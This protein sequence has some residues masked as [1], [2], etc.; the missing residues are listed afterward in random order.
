MDN[1]KVKIHGIYKHFKGDLYIVEDIAYHSETGEKM[2]VYRALYGDGKAWCRPYD[3]FLSE[4]DHEKYPEIRQKYRFEL[5][6]I[7]SVTE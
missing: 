4:V 6:E 5:Q 7:K 2:V 3:L 1:H